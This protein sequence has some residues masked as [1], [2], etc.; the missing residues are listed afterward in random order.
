LTL[1]N[2]PHLEVTLYDD[3]VHV[4]LTEFDRECHPDGTSTN[5][6]HLMT[7]CHV[8]LLDRIELAR[9]HIHRPTPWHSDCSGVCEAGSA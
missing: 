4:A 6:D 9:R 5:D 2:A 8:C 1:G 7:F 3:A